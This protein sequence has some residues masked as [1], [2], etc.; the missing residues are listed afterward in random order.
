VTPLSL[1]H[2]EWLS[3][4]AMAIV[5][6]A[7]ALA[8]AR[9]LA[10]HRRIRLLGSRLPPSR[11]SLA[12]DAM[13]F[14]AALAIAVALL[15]PRIGER[16]VRV[17]FSGIDVVFL[18]D[19]S[20]SMDVR[21][22]PPSR[23]DR[24]RRAVEEILARLPPGDRAGLAAFAGRG[25]LLAPLTPDHGALVDLLAALDSDSI[26]PASSNLAAGVDAALAAFES[27]S[28][29]PRVLVVAS[30]G[31]DSN[32]GRKLGIETA[33]ASRTRVLTIA[34]GSEAGGV[35][36]DGERPLR[37][38]DGAIVLSQRQRDPLARLAKASDGEAFVADEFGRIDFAR[39]VAS[40]QRD[41][42]AGDGWIE[43]RVPAIGTAP[44][45]VVA[46][47]LLLLEGLPR[48]RRRLRRG[49]TAS[50]SVVAV[51]AAA[52][53]HG[54]GTP[55]RDGDGNDARAHSSEAAD[56]AAVLAHARPGDA[57]AQL[58]LGL[59]NLAAG[60]NEA[61]MR[62]F[63]AATVFARSGA[64][65]AVAF[66]DLGVASLANG[67]RDAARDAFFAAL[68]IDPSD[69]QARFN[70]EWTLRDSPAPKPEPISEGVSK[71]GAENADAASESDELAKDARDRVPEIPTLSDAQRRRWLERANDDA[72]PWL[73]AAAAMPR[74][75]DAHTTRPAW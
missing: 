23:L 6:C 21:D 9:W 49:L 69:E 8:I 15:G 63:Q 53:A 37:D 7:T 31:E 43:Q 58:D 42:G 24:A 2:P 28:D 44:F 11:R 3:A 57:R 46:F 45:A 50:I 67:D 27:G 74:E 19:V 29:R 18:I 16:V 71:S 1:V 62:A 35:V 20:R 25:L 40:I 4:I 64:L 10:R 34:L 55:K 52:G 41:A 26:E 66:Y 12:S 47:G 59:A 68:D 56:A 75:R 33:R 48:P 73:R 17:P 14:A 32:R 38:R 70:L 5:V 36:P 72:R 54:D 30:D 13:L 39:A 51:L 61:A 60:R 22:T 65:S